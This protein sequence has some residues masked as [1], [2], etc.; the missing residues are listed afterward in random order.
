MTESLVSIISA[1]Y[2]K[3]PYL[4]RFV[5]SII[6]QNYRPIELIM[7]DDGSTD[8]SWGI[9]QELEQVCNQNNIRTKFRHQPNQGVGAAINTCLRD[10]EGEYLC[11]P[12]CDDWLEK[13][14]VSK[15]VRFLQKNKRYD[16]V[17]SNADI[18]NE[19]DFTKPIGRIANEKDN[20]ENQFYSMLKGK[21]IVCPGCHMVRTEALL[22]AMGGSQ[23]FPSRYGQ[24][25]Q[26]LYPI[27]YH[28]PRGFINE[29]LYHYVIY[30]K[31]LS[32][33]IASF[34]KEWC[35]RKGRYQIKCET[36]R[37][38]NGMSLSER[39]RCLRIVSIQEARY[40]LSIAEKY[41]RIDVAKK[42]VGVLIKYRRLRI[43]DV[44]AL[45]HIRL[46]NYY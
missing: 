34:E 41:K 29:P 15:R 33:D 3:A 24:N 9:L 45:V 8:Q 11:W 12:D 27:L 5:Q 2:N 40:R 21:S 22:S 26:L 23:I 36:L 6:D 16:I 46:M 31:S 37:R 35:H 39:K 44:F 17:S 14:S 13:T 4:K 32:H 28:S 30:E 18:F 25:L 10:I 19:W 20:K 7:V 38:I 43:R 1:C 42:Q